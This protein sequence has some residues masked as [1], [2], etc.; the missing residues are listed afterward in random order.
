M[1]T[2]R[3]VIDGDDKKHFCLMVRDGTLTVGA[4]PAHAGIVLGRLRV[5]RIHCEG[6]V[7]E[8]PVVVGNDPTT[9]GGSAARPRTARG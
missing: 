8:G 1:P 2:Q 6:D 4:D 7:E 5:V 3:L 9:P